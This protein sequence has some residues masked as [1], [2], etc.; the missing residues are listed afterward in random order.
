M[1]CISLQIQSIF[2]DDLFIWR[3]SSPFNNPL[4]LK[5]NAVHKPYLGPFRL[6]NRLDRLKELSV[7]DEIKRDQTILIDQLKEKLI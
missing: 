2:D 5:R 1:S 3:K 4:Y 7:P 6:F